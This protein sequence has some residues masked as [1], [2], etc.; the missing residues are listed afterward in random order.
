MAAHLI[1]AIGFCCDR[2]GIILWT[3]REARLEPVGGLVMQGALKEVGIKHRFV[4]GSY[5]DPEEI[6]KIISTAA[7]AQ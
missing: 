1:A 3:I 7:Q 2:E 5:E 4:Y 6:E